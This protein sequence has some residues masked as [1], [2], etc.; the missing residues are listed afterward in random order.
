M[1]FRKEAM[2]TSCSN[3]NPD[4]IQGKNLSPW[5]W[6]NSRT[7]AQ[8][9][10]GISL[11]GGIQNWIG[12]EQPA[13]AFKL[14]LFWTE[15]WTWRICGGPFQLKFF[16]DSLRCWYTW[17]LFLYFYWALVKLI[18]FSFVLAASGMMLQLL[19][20]CLGFSLAY[21]VS[22]FLLYVGISLIRVLASVQNL[23]SEVLLETFSF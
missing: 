12:P 13:L 19:M 5:E 18:L 7:D 14:P 16:W 4:G 1:T 9:C 11:L 2:D 6:W 23:L 15:D 20:F 8:G 3:G 21:F 22:L 17:I 10:C